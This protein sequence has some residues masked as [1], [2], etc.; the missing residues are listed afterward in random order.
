MFMSKRN[1]KIKDEKRFDVIDAFRFFF[2][3]VVSIFAASLFFDICIYIAS[4]CTGVPKETLDKSE[5]VVIL[6]TVMSPFVFI[7]YS[8][9]YSLVRKVRL[10]TSFNDGQPISL[11]PISVSIVLAIIAIFLFR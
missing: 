3:L 10:G 9:V 11:L 1:V 2:F 4:F 7:V 5:A 6:S 8:I